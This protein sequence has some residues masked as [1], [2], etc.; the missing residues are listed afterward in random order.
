M[1]EDFE[2]DPTMEKPK[3]GKRDFGAA[4]DGRPPLRSDLLPSML[5][6]TEDDLEANQR[7]R[8]TNRQKERINREVK[9]E[10]DSMWLM[11]GIFLGTALLLAL[12]FTLEGLPIATMLIGA[13]AV[14]LPFMYIAYRRQN[15]LVT[16]MQGD[17]I[18]QV[19]GYAELAM[20]SA[21]RGGIFNY[22]MIVNREVIKIDEDAYKRLSRYAP[23]YIRAYYSKRGKILLSAE[24]I[25][26][27]QH[28]LKNDALQLDEADDEPEAD[29]LLE[30]GQLAQRQPEKQHPL[31]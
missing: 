1:S 9:D 13:G 8:L 19:E 31:E 20:Q 25:D 17:R 24:M 23:G 14:V 6:F 29:I 15:A 5:G 11:L 18:G 30:Q 22:R 26:D 12:I 21:T 4:L 10:A 7:G 3:R 27:G 28:K 2:F 16:D